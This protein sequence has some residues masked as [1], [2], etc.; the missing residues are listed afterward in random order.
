M[1]VAYNFVQGNEIKRLKLLFV[2]DIV[3]S[4]DSIYNALRFRIIQGDSK[5]LERLQFFTWLV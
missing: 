5:T 2:V 3:I 4:Y 1:Y